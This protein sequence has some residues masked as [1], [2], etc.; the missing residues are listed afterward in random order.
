MPDIMATQRRLTEWFIDAG[1]ASIITL[2]PMVKT[3]VPGKGISQ[4][5]GIARQPQKFKKIWPGGDG[6]QTGTQDGSYHKFDMIIVGLH[7]CVAEVGDTW[8]EGSQQYRIHSEFPNN[9][10]ERKFG[11]F[12]FGGEPKDG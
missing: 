5:P 10:Y 2:V 1:P 4:A 12:S 9:G 11:V 8:E 7:D 3:K 6:L